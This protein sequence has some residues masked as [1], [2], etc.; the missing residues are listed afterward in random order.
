[1]KMIKTMIGFGAI[2]S[3]ALAPA[4]VLADSPDYTYIEGSY[5]NIDI[6]GIDD[7][8]GF[9]IGGS[10]EVGE[11]IFIFADYATVGFS[12][13]VDFDTITAGIGYKSAISDTTDVNVSIAYVNAEVDAGVFGSIDDDGYG[14]DVS[15]RSMVS[16]EFELN[17]GISYVDF[18]NGGDDTAFHFGGVYSFND[19]FA[20]TGDI[21]FGEDITSFLIGGRFYVQ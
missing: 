10:A 11:N 2:A 20:V 1:M 19:S 9:G 15:L 14:L 16:S 4:A 8:D 7:G 18:G 12:F 3:L 5:V 17:G 13:G 6:D 21:S